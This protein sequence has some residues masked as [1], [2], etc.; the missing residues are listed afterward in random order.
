MGHWITP[1]IS[2][3]K[4]YDRGTRSWAYTIISTSIDAVKAEVD[5]LYEI[6]P[7]AGYATKHSLTVMPGGEHRAI[8]SHWASCD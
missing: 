8:V 1:E 4:R 2:V 7:R 3:V 5:K 6:W